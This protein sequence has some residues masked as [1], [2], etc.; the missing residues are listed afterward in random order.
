MGKQVCVISFTRD[1]L[2]EYIE[3]P[4]TPLE[5]AESVDMMRVLEN[6]YRVTMIPT[7]HESYSIDVDSDKK[8]VEEYLKERSIN[9]S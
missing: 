5:I 8:K 6:G 7:K 2:L 1:F 3:M 4:P 9:H